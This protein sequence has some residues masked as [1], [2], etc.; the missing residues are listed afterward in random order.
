M[1]TLRQATSSLCSGCQFLLIQP[2][3]N[4]ISQKGTLFVEM[5]G[6]LV[7][8]RLLSE[9]IHAA[10]QDCV[11]CKLVMAM[12]ETVYQWKDFNLDQIYGFKL[13]LYWFDNTRGFKRIEVVPIDCESEPLMLRG[14]MNYIA[15]DLANGTYHESAL[16]SKKLTLSRK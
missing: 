13:A 12:Q 3:R 11:I 10:I 4:P 2:F 14:R 6:N 1:E 9:A 15:L 16:R 5:P 8:S 7:V